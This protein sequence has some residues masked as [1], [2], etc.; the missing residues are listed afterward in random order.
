MAEVESVVQGSIGRLSALEKMSKQADERRD[1]VENELEDL[2]TNPEEVTEI[3]RQQLEDK[4]A[5]CEE[6]QRE[7]SEYQERYSRL[8]G[9]ATRPRRLP[10]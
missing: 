1:E 4:I 5:E 2:K 6:L 7:L 10:T 3:A 8:E 9:P